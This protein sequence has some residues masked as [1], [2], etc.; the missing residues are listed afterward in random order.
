VAGRLKG[1]AS[2]R[3]VPVQSRFGPA[4][5][6]N[7]AERSKGRRQLNPWRSWY[8]EK[9][10]IDLRLQVLA[11]ED[12]TCRM[13]GHKEVQDTSRL[14][15]DHIIPHRG[16]RALFLDRGNVQ[17]LCKTCHDTRKQ[18]AERAGGW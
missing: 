5:W 2:T 1:V 3:L 4:A 11:E 10:W 8:S 6:V 9:A 15:G 17:C 14:V 7:E 13:C 12:F 18:A 16:D